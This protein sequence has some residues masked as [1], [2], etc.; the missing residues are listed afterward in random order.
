MENI[1]TLKQSLNP[2]S[3]SYQAEVHFNTKIA[4]HKKTRQSPRET[5]KI[6]A[7]YDKKRIKNTFNQSPYCRNQN[8]IKYK[9]H[10]QDK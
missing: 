7:I 2:C 6:N 8:R 5:T 1:Q 3:K 9:T 10:K 4:G